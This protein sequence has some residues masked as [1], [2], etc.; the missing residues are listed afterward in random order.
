MHGHAAF[1]EALAESGEVVASE[2]LPEQSL[3]K[4]VSLREGRTIVADG[5]FAEV[6][7]HLVDFYLIEC[8]NIERAIELAARVPDAARR[9]C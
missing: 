3:A 6:K 8:E 2:G 9:R 7:E 4:R 1:H 5:P